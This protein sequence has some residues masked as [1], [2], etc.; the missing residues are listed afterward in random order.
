[1]KEKRR[2]ANM[3][4][5]KNSLGMDEK[6]ASWFAYIVS[7]ISAIILLASEKDNRTVRLHAWQSLFLGCLWVALWIVLGLL[8][9]IPFVGIVFWIILYLAHVGFIVLTV[10]CIIKATQNDIFKIPVIY[11]LAEK[12]K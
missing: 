6:T 2:C 10:I 5:Q 8:G 1:M 9:W 11:G 3:S 12:M 7:I 4:D